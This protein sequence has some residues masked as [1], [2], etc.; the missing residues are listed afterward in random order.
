MTATIHIDPTALRVNGFYVH[1]HLYL[2][3][4][5]VGCCTCSAVFCWNNKTDRES[6]HARV[7][8][9]RIRVRVVVFC[10]ETIIGG[11]IQQLSVHSVHNE[12][13]NFPSDNM[14]HEG[15]VP[16]SVAHKHPQEEDWTETVTTFKKTNGRPCDRRVKRSTTT[17]AYNTKGR[18]TTYPSTR[19]E[20]RQQRYYRLLLTYNSRYL[21][22]VKAKV[23]P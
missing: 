8:V 22:C 1:T 15:K 9:C 18:Q 17:A 6:A 19:A 2:R 12:A 4:F 3:M 5:C 14:R 23:T 11:K 21:F 10:V 13:S 20:T 7:D 16:S